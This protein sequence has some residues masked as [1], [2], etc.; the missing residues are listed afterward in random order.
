MIGQGGDCPLCQ[1]VGNLVY[2]YIYINR[3][4]SNKV[5]K[6]EGNFEKDDNKI[7]I[8][9]WNIIDKIK[10]RRKKSSQDWFLTV[11]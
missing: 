6:P 2:Y 3:C 9:L 10:N 7:G 1:T 4:F 11:M 5:N 8:E